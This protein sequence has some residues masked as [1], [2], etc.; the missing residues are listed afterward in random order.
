M[1]DGFKI[2]PYDRC[3]AN[4]VINSKQCTIVFYVDDN[5]ISHVDASVNS[6][7][8]NILKGRFGDLTITRG[9]QHK[10]LGMGMTFNDNG[11]VKIEMKKLLS[12]TIKMVDEKSLS[13]K[14]SSPATKKLFHISEEPKQLDTKQSELFHKIIAKILYICKRSRP[15]LDTVLAF[16]CT[17]V[18]KSN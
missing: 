11:T 16:L 14:V 2:N 8:L 15:D 13:N 7:V 4:R 5:K 1:K 17:R 6:D 9:K 10:F 18:A 3:V 12:D